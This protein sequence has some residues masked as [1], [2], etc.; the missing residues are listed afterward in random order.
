MRLF[1]NQ[2]G[3]NSLLET[4]HRGVPT[5]TLPIFPDELKNSLQAELYG[6]SLN[7]PYKEITE[8]N[9]YTLIQELLENPKYS[10]NAKMRSQMFLDRPL[11]PIDNAVYWIEYVVKYHGA[12]HLKVAAVSLSLVE[13]Y[14]LDVLGA[15]SLLILL[16]VFSLKIVYSIICKRQILRRKC[17]KQ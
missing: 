8:E 6:Y 17:K 15:L 11:K 10:N 12:D 1:I 4:V 5:L 9:L 16:F 13:I 2:G 14:M 3:Y 7:L